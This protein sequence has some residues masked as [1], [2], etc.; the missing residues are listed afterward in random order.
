MD[1]NTDE[2]NLNSLVLAMNLLRVARSQRATCGEV[3]H[4]LARV[5]MFV[6]GG[7]ATAEERDSSLCHMENFISEQ[8]RQLQANPGPLTQVH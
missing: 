1:Q 7:M 5:Q 4:A 8:R 2:F 6:I 3:L